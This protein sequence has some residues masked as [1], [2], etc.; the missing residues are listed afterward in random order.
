MPDISNLIVKMNNAVRTA[1]RVR[2]TSRLAR[3]ATCGW[4]TCVHDRQGMR[5]INFQGFMVGNA[6]T[7]AA[8]D[9]TGAV[10]DWYSHNLIA[11]DT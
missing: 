6:W 4:C 7:D 1:R 8:I 5:H 9:N 3:N 2:A 10:F 11:E